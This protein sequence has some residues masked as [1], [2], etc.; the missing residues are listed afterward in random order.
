MRK[1]EDKILKDFT[2]RKRRKAQTS[3]GSRT[4]KQIMAYSPNGI[5]PT[6]KNTGAADGQN[7]RMNLPDIMHERNQTKEGM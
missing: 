3:I 7:T 6:D 1:N 5:L 4:G 2:K